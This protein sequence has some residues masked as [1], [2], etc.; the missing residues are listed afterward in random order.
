MARI[1]LVS[2]SFLPRLGGVE[3]H[4]A[5]VAV[6]LRDMGHEIAIWSVDQGDEVPSDFDGMTLRY[7]PTPLPARNIVDALQFSMRAPRALAAW[8]DALR[9]DR[10]EIMHV[11][12]FGPNGVYATAMSALLR[13]PTIF[14]HHGETF[15]DAD[16]V[17]QRSALLRLSLKSMLARAVAVTSCS[18]FAAQDLER[19]GKDP[20]EVNIVYNGI[21]LHEESEG[22]LLLPPRYV[23]GVGRL[24]HNKG[25][26]RL[27]ESYSTVCREPSMR[28]TDLV[29]GGDG[30]ERL[31][32]QELSRKKGIDDRV[33]FLGALSRSEVG[34]AMKTALLLV[35]PS[36][37]EPFGIT[38]LERV[39]G[40]AF[41]LSP[42]TKEGLPSSWSTTSTAF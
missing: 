33:H 41:L 1:V 25:F 9:R 4:V 39:G 15:M 21:N 7:L 28:E 29:I 5:N 23:L 37:V 26:D 40:P 35:V 34:Q 36:I 12:C 11:H 20:R 14:S 13:C 10:P 30:P 42:P 22:N 18:H 6:N 32:L 24:V 19:F 38:I 17:F 8:L 16:E 27:L 2:S 31:H 3:E